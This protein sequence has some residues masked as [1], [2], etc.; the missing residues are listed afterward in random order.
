MEDVVATQASQRVFHPDKRRSNTTLKVLLEN[1]A[2]VLLKGKLTYEIDDIKI[3]IN[4]PV[5]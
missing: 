5:G 1:F 4:S 3:E 2:T